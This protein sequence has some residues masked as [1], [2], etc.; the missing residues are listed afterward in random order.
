MAG[1]PCF[2]EERRKEGREAPFWAHADRLSCLLAS[3]P[4]DLLLLLR[5]PAA[6]GE[7]R[8]WSCVLPPS[9]AK[10]RVC[11]AQHLMNGEGAGGGSGPRV[12]RAMSPRSPGTW[13][14]PERWLLP[15]TTRLP[16]GPPRDPTPRAGGPGRAGRG[17][18]VSEDRRKERERRGGAGRRVEKRRPPEGRRGA[19]EAGQEER[20]AWGARLPEDL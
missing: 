19:A 1:R 17:R 3:W 4:L 11:G 12:T 8:R 18:D 6:T 14:C 5:A 7:G 9:P 15:S 16:A 10:P 2:Q 13:P 20:R